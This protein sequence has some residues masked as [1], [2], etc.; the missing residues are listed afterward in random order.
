MINGI[1]PLFTREE[2]RG[3]NGVYMTQALFY[4]QPSGEDEIAKFTL[5]DYDHKGYISMYLVYMQYDTEYEAALRLLGSWKHWCKLK[6]LAW[7]KEHVDA[8]NAERDLRDKALAK[9]QLKENA[10]NG[11]V[12]AQ[13]LL[14][15]GEEKKTT[16]KKKTEEKK[17]GDV[18]DLGAAAEKF[19][20]K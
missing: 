4:E 6:E 11:N 3:K 15:T 1:E 8:W 16:R 17:A 2:L 19:L 18:V 13:R 10:E 7:F 20:N 9:Q 14:Y 5:K 12:T